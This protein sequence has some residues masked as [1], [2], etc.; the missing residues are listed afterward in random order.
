METTLLVGNKLPTLRVWERTF[1][2]VTVHAW[3]RRVRNLLRTK[4][5]ITV[6]HEIE[7]VPSP[8]YTYSEAQD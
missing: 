2:C 4:S 7:P 6:Q 5:K 8:Q 1:S 3:N